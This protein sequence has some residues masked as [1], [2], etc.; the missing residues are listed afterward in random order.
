MT[1]EPI[2][3]D[4]DMEPLKHEN[5]VLREQ[6]AKATSDAA[7]YRKAAYE[8]LEEVFP[9]TLPNEEEIQQILHGP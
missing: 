3:S 6:L 4:D 8:M 9:C 1:N 7:E 2:R 5:A